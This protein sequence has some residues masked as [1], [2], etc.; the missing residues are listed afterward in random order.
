MARLEYTKLEKSGDQTTV[1]HNGIS[2]VEENMA[3]L[4]HKYSERDS[5]LA[6][7]S[8]SFRNQMIMLKTRAATL[9]K[10]AQILVDTERK[11]STEKSQFGAEMRA[12]QRENDIE[13]VA[14]EAR[15]K[16]ALERLTKGSEKKI[17]TARAI[18]EYKVKMKEA[19]REEE[20]LSEM[21]KRLTLRIFENKNDP[22]FAQ[23]AQ[24]FIEVRK[25]KDE[26][27]EVDGD[28]SEVKGKLAKL[29]SKLSELNRNRAIVNEIH[30]IHERLPK[31]ED[32][33]Q[34]I[35]LEIKEV[36]G[37]QR[38][39]KSS[40]ALAVAEFNQVMRQSDQYHRNNKVQKKLHCVMSM[41]KIERFRAS[42]TEYKRTLSELK[43][44]MRQEQTKIKE[45]TET[46]ANLKKEIEEMKGACEIMDE[47]HQSIE[48]ELKSVNEQVAKDAEVTSCSKE[49]LR[50]CRAQMKEQ[51]ADETRL[52]MQAEIMD[53]DD[54]ELFD[55]K[56]AELIKQ[57]DLLQE[58]KKIEEEKK[59]LHI[60]IEAC[61][62]ELNVWE[63]EYNRLTFDRSSVEKESKRMQKEFPSIQGTDRQSILK[64]I[65]DLSE[66]VSQKMRLNKARS[67]KLD[68][69]KKQL[70][71]DF[72][73]WT[74]RSLN[75]SGSTGS[76]SPLLHG[77]PMVKAP[78]MSILER[79]LSKLSESFAQQSDIWAKQADPNECGSL[80]DTWGKQLDV[81]NTKL[82]EMVSK[83]KI[84]P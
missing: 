82:S 64:T 13:T 3:K 7:I 38:S 71:D 1:L 47:N 73:Y 45:D 65:S 58:L 14:C 56:N 40:H 54:K 43:M 24:A 49:D 35:R 22:V 31:I 80:L 19:E 53:I 63:A 42:K 12:K 51:I 27:E 39:A 52:K 59:K 46:E 23:A 55:A 8:R 72:E 28:T 84:W 79:Y 62:W 50:K 11:L 44:K 10:Y 70:E 67:E 15:M 21:M 74:K 29:D 69:R 78:Q 2:Y 57:E 77:S 60:Q 66:R 37:K 32:Q 61:Y 25:L 83:K 16:D 76:I 48:R 33:I 34:R 17:Q 4:V 18:D 9:Q 41:D 36:K 81:A 75:S 68:R 26:I 6:Q 30:E 5:D 20:T